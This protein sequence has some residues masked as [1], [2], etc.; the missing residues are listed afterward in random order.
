MA[1]DAIGRKRRVLIIG[2]TIFTRDGPVSTRERKS[3]IVVRKGRWVPNGCRV[4]GLAVRGQSTRHVVGVGGRGKLRAV[5]RI[6]VRRRGFECGTLMTRRARHGL[7][8]PCQWKG[9]ETIVVEG[10]RPCERRSQM[11]FST[12]GRKARRSMVGV[13]RCREITP[14]TT[15]TR[16]RSTDILI[17]RGIRMAVLAGE[18]RVFARQR[19]SRRLVFLDHI[20]YCPRLCRVASETIR[21]ELRL[22][23]V[24]VA[25]SAAITCLCKLQVLV[26]AG[27]GDRLVLAVE[28]K[29]RL[30]VIEACI[31]THA[32]RVGRVAGLTRNLD[33]SVGR[34][35]GDSGKSTRER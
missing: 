22:V 18:R 13:G 19:E 29:A 17:V 28:H 3:C 4:T 20:G 5:T 7:M 24:G 21:S 10:C 11:A 15:D 6:A 12:I 35:L 16:R 34:L 9:G 31:G 30:R 8:S 33:I 32:P 23:D 1:I 14:M 26:A 27:A 2:M 25:R